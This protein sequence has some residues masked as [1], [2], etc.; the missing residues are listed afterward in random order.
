MEKE[1]ILYI[2]LPIFIITCII[3]FIYFFKSFQ[4]VIDEIE[5]VRNQAMLAKNFTELLI[6]SENLVKIVDKCW[7]TIQ[8]NKLKEVNTIID[9]KFNMLKNT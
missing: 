3:F 7:H 5:V 8:F 9:V 2:G 6:A 1:L 4:K